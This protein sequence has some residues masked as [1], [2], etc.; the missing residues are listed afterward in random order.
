[1]YPA[2]ASY[3]LQQV[4]QLMYFNTNPTIANWH[5]SLR[6]GCESLTNLHAYNAMYTPVSY[7]NINTLLTTCLAAPLILF[8]EVQ[9][10]ILQHISF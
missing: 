7:Y 10:S 1:M 8:V 4:L 5:S 9:Y 2:F 6:K 3:A